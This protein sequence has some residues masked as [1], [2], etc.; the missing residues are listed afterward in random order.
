MF[1]KVRNMIQGLNISQH[2]L[3]FIR[4]PQTPALRRHQ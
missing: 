1:P 3:L 2:T 4:C